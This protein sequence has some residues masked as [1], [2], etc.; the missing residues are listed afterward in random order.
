MNPPQARR[1]SR[2]APAFV[3]RGRDAGSVINRPA[4]IVGTFDAAPVFPEIRVH[5]GGF[6]L[7]DIGA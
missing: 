6:L 7:S 4:H 2:R 1:P 5:E 3:S